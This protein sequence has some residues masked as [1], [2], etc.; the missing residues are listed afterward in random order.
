[1]TVFAEEIPPALDGE[2]IDRVVAMITGCSRSEA[3]AAIGASTV[4][5]DAVVATKPSV[6]VTVGQ[7]VSISA[8]PTTIVEPPGP[9]ASVEFTT[10]Y[11]DDAIVVVDKPA[12]LVVHPGA[13]HEGVTLVNGLLARFPDVE[14]VGEVH[15]PGIV[16]RLDR[17]T[18]GLM[19]V[20]RTA[21]AHEAL[22]EQLA[23][24]EMGRE[25]RALAWGTFET[26]RG[27]IDAPVGRSRRDPLRMTVAADGREARTHYEVLLAF[28]DPEVTLL[29]CHL[30]TGR[31]HQIRVHLRGI[32]R[33][34][35]GDD[36]YGG[37]R[38]GLAVGRPFLHAARLS[39]HHP[40]TD[41]EMTFESPLPADLEAVLDGLGPSSD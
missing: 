11:E 12:G 41:E 14:G 6:R 3:S 9:D 31:T 19:V 1:M 35:V 34:V 4:T 27:T 26:R 39:L 28:E 2:R 33:P 30:E 10:V 32:G 15:R 25:Y 23:T 13:G 5:V 20:A 17:G 8:D 7:L 18:S 40:V 16:H 29:A 36:L 37:V 24:H 38:P 21:E 22:V